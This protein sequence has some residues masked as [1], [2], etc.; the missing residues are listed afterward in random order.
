VGG[1]G[2]RSFPLRR[3]RDL[4]KV[5]G[6]RDLL[7]I[8][9][10]GAVPRAGLEGLGC[11]IRRK[12]FGKGCFLLVSGGGKKGRGKLCFVLECL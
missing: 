11:R 2:A 3:H 10:K 8:L 7:L 12:G 6:G 1:T 5:G 9:D 4:K